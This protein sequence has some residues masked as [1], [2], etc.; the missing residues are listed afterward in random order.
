MLRHRLLC[1]GLVPV[2]QDSGDMAVS[3]RCPACDA[4]EPLSV[5]PGGGAVRGDGVVVGGDRAGVCRVVDPRDEPT[6]AFAIRRD[7]LSDRVDGFEVVDEV[8]VQAVRVA[9]VMP[10]RSR[11]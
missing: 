1:D 6:A 9:G 5:T 10:V 3:V 11:T 4:V 8:A 2:P 7:D